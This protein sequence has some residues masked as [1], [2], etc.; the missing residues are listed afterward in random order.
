MSEEMR[1]EQR[2]SDMDAL[3]WQ[4]E[5]DPM[6]RSTITAV[7]ILDAEPDVDTA[8]RQDRAWGTG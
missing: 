5:K 3:M 2:M 8:L 6:L 1:F 7:S 4:I